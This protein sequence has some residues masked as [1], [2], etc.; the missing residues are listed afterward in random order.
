MIACT[1]CRTILASDHLNTGELFACPVCRTKLRAD[2]FPAYNRALEA[3][4]VGD[5]IHEQG[6]AECYNHPGRQAV[7]PCAACGR[8]LCA[9]CEIQ[10]DGRSL[11]TAC[12]QSGRRKQKIASLENQR[13]LYDNMALAVAFWP[14]LT[15]F[16]TLLTAP[17]ALFMI[18]RYWKAP[19]SLLPRTRFRFILA[20]LISVGQLF[21]WAVFFVNIFG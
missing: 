2:V 12:M 16:F 4:A 17:V 20:G 11:C 9:L 6:Q 10:I 14:M 15:V 13:T 1:N 7:V 19:S 3:G 8:L 5:T 18:I 21:G